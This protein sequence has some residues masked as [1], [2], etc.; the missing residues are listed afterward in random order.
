MLANGTLKR[1]IK[2][3]LEP[4]Y[5]NLPKF[6]DR[7]F[8][9]SLAQELLQALKEELISELTVLKKTS[10]LK[11]IQWGKRKNLTKLG[12]NFHKPMLILLKL[13]T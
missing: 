8:Y 2:A 4:H 3:N 5:S 13:R 11:V 12:D 6:Y 10:T 9:L 7:T 1:R